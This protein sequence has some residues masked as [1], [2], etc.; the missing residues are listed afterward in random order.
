MPSAPIQIQTDEI[1]S[2]Y[3]AARVICLGKHLASSWLF[4]LDRFARLKNGTR[5]HIKMTHQPLIGGLLA[6]YLG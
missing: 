6:V 5:L 1:K 3:I 4:V 2:D